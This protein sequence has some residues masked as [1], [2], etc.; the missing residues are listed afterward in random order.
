MHAPSTQVADILLRQ[1]PTIL[2]RWDVAARHE[3]EPAR[4]QSKPALYDELPGFLKDIAEGLRVGYE[5][6]QLRA[7]KEKK[8]SGHGIERAKAPEYTLE[9]ML[10]EYHLLR[11]QVI[12]SLQAEVSVSAADCA[13]I[14][15]S[16]D[17]AMRVAAQKFSDFR[18]QE[19]RDGVVRLKTE[20][21][22]RERFVA[23]LTHDLRT[24]LT[25]ILTSA[26]L[27]LR[28]PGLPEKC[29]NL[30]SRIVTG[31][32]RADQMIRDLL[33]ANLIQA[34]EQMALVFEQGELEAIVREAVDEI[35]SIHGQRVVLRCAE[36]VSGSWSTKELR[37]ATENLIQ[38][39]IKYGDPAEPILVTIFKEAEEAIIEVRNFGN[40][41][42]QEDQETLF[43]QYRRG[44]SALASGKKGWGLG[45]TLVRGIAEAHGGS[46][47][48]RSDAEEGTVFT[49]RLPLEARSR[50]QA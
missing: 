20:R 42:R 41:I 50:T 46:V 47:T 45:L 17:A 8:A 7:K 38:N 27:I 9:Q 11:D 1:V 5:G 48:V 22:L 2:Q 49:I 10:F 12:D 37:R 25:G 26:Q 21:E 23:T 32:Y 16:I 44:D 33:D 40:P 29:L 24:P 15:A 35:S 30:A 13:Y 19:E 31:I 14:H 43:M 28:V 18:L 4:H 6:R 39:A 36:P 3:L 34:G